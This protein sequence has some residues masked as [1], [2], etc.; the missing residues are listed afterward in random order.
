MRSE[1]IKIIID[2]L[3]PIGV[4]ALGIFGM[5]ISYLKGRQDL[6]KFQKDKILKEQQIEY[7]I[8]QA[9]KTSELAIATDKQVENNT[10][11]IA[12]IEIQQ[13]LMLKAQL[14]TMKSLKIHGINGKTDESIAEIENY[15]L[16]NNPI[17]ITI[18]EDKK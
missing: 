16:N 12:M 10:L 7:T 3:Y 13:R 18:S 14:N 1:Q 2:I 5:W 11:R 8:K 15:L 9:Q 17:K 6:K 4:F